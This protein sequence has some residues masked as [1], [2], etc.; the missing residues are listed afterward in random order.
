MAGKRKG[1]SHDKK[2][3]N[4]KTRHPEGRKNWSK[5]KRQ[6]GFKRGAAETSYVRRILK[7]KGV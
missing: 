2:I 7:E 6:A 3:A 4:F 5:R 1:K